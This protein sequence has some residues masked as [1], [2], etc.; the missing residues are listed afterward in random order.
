MN[1][2]V[3]I[4][5]N[6]MR[7]PVIPGITVAAALLNGG[8]DGFRTSITGESRGPLCGMGICQECRVTIDDVPHQRSCLVLVTAGMRVETGHA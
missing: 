7:L 8:I 2:P 4:V 5:A 6:G 1:G 3:E